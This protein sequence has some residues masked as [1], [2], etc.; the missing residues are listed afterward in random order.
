MKT[1]SETPQLFLGL[2]LDITRG[3]EPDLDLGP[4]V[5]L[6]RV[7]VPDLGLDLVVLNENI[8]ESKRVDWILHHR[9]RR[10][11]RGIQTKQLNDLHM[12]RGKSRSMKFLRF[13]YLCTDN[14]EI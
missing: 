3:R 7:L 6:D 13:P 12:M 8:A 4:V 2:V 14:T 11:H 1:S 10:R 9:H 5:D